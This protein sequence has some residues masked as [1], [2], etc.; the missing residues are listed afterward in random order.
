MKHGFVDLWSCFDAHKEAK[1]D[2]YGGY[3]ALDYVWRE[4]EGVKTSEAFAF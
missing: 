2:P 3:S 1:W 4:V